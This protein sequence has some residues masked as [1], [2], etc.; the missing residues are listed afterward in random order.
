METFT[1]VKKVLKDRE[2][3]ILSME[4]KLNR[5]NSLSRT[6]LDALV[7]SIGSSDLLSYDERQAIKTETNDLCKS[8]DIELSLIDEELDTKSVK[9]IG[10]IEDL[11]NY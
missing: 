1:R 2:V 11:D 9:P 7:R 6:L 4:K 3:A 8:I 5:S 10:K